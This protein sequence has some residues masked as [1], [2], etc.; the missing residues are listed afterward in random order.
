MSEKRTEGKA[1]L[2]AL[3]EKNKRIFS[4]ELTL[5]RDRMQKGEN[6]ITVTESC[7]RGKEIFLKALREDDRDTARK[8]FREELE[9]FRA[10]MAGYRKL[11]EQSSLTGGCFSEEELR[12]FRESSDRLIMEAELRSRIFETSLRAGRKEEE[13]DDFLWLNAINTALAEAA[14]KWEKGRFIP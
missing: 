13:R 3:G 12:K 8:T 7:R 4:A 9:L 1:G 10:L 2:L 6:F 5:P 14:G 11:T